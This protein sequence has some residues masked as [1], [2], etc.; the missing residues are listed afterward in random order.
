MENPHRLVDRK[1][2][3]VLVEAILCKM[4]VFV[5]AHPIGNGSCLYLQNRYFCS[6]VSGFT[7]F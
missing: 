1:F 2:L 7:T 4:L 3:Q 6:L 5:S